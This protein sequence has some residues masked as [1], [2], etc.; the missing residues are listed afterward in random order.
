[1]ENCEIEQAIFREIEKEVVRIIREKHMDYI[2]K[3]VDDNIEYIVDEFFRSAREY[4]HEQIDEVIVDAMR[5]K[6]SQ[7]MKDVELTKKSSKV[8]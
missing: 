8:K 5:E 1:M 7:Y 2:E 3:V 6:V 4:G